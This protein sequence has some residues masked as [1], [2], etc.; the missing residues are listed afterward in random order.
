MKAENYVPM[1]WDDGQGGQWRATEHEQGGQPA[2]KWDNNQFVLS[3]R[4]QW[5]GTDETQKL[6]ALVFIAPQRGKYTI[7]ATVSAFAWDGG[8]A[9]KLQILLRDP[10]E[11][12]NKGSRRLCRESQNDA[13]RD[14]RPERLRGKRTGDCFSAALPPP[15]IR[16]E[17]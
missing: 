1:P 10:G 2:A 14:F 8:G 7:S 5:S 6:P 17:T 3:G 12:D 13:N 9:D 11:K 16:P 4:S 15:T